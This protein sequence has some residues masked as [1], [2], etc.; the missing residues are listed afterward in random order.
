MQLSVKLYIFPSTERQ[1][2]GIDLAHGDIDFL[3]GWRLWVGSA[4]AKYVWPAPLFATFIH[5]HC[6][7][8]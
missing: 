3:R 1:C 8:P 5:H 6:Q 7:L 4:R 2:T